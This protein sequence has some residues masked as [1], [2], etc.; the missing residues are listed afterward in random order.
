MRIRLAE[1]LRSA[2]VSQTSRS[3]SIHAAADASRT[4]ALHVRVGFVIQHFSKIGLTIL[5]ALSSPVTTE[6]QA[7]DWPQWRGLNR[8]GVWNEIGILQTF[9]AEGLN[10]RGTPGGVER[11]LAAPEVLKKSLLHRAFTGEL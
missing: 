7:A 9:P 6:V 5:L 3:T 8:D 2:A 4:A 10:V 11:K 1:H